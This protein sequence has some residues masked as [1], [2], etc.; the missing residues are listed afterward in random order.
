MIA[1]FI[2]QHVSVSGVPQAAIMTETEILPAF[3]QVAET[4]QAYSAILS[5]R[6]KPLR[7]CFETVQKD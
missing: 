2:P 1:C 6:G 5:H 7:V 4:T 3:H